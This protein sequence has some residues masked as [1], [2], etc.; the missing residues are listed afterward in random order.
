MRITAYRSGDGIYL[1]PH[2][3]QAG[4]PD[5]PGVPCLKVEGMDETAIGA[6]VERCIADAHI[7]EHEDSFDQLMRLAGVKNLKAFQRDA[8]IV[9]I[10]ATKH[11][12]TFWPTKSMGARKGYAFIDGPSAVTAPDAPLMGRR[13]IQAFDMCE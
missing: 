4:G 7:D 3:P 6:A 2:L 13:V 12:I 10:D 5:L 11:E 8:R 9:S 1:Q